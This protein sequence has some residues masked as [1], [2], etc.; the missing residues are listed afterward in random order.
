MTRRK[1]IGAAVFGAAAVGMAGL[2]AA[3]GY[4]A[5]AKDDDDDEDERGEAN[6]RSEKAQ[7]ATPNSAP[8]Q[9]PPAGAPQ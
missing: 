2:V 4:F 6:E 5:V 3:A 1:L 9:P 7:P 8:T